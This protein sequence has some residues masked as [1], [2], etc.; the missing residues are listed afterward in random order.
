LALRAR[1]ER[2]R[3]AG[4]ALFISLHADAL[5]EE[6]KVHGLSVYTLS[7][8][9]SDA[10][11]AAL[12]QKENRADIITGVD[13]SG[14]QEDVMQILI[15]LAQRQTM[16]QSEAFADGLTQELRGRALLVKN[17][18][19][20]AGFRV[21]KAPDVPSVLIELGYLSNTTD[22][23]NLKSDAWRKSMAL[24]LCDAIG[25]HFDALDQRRAERAGG[26]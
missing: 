22:L 6:P 25:R 19:R 20:S 3:V 15:D 26:G 4:A 5:P 23:A 13:L 18:H 8:T 1:V 24:A 11:A 7:N 2:A 10:E 14:E 12:A 17:A 16:S 21:L 9:A